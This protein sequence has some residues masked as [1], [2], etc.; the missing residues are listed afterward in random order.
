MKALIDIDRIKFSDGLIPAVIQDVHN[1]DV[2]MVAYMN[3]E[4][5]QLS[6]E[7]GETHFWSRSRKQLWHK[8]ETSG[9]IQKI[10]TIFVDC[11]QD[12]LL[13]E[14]EQVEAACH[15]GKR[16]CF[17]EKFWE[18]NVCEGEEAPLITVQVL[19]ALSQ[20]IL[21]RKA[22]PS[23]ESYTS[24][25]FEGGLDLIL[26]KVAEES[27]E[28]IISAK[29][30]RE[31]EIV[32]ETADLLYHLLVTLGYYGIPMKRIEDELKKRT[33]QSGLAEKESREKSPRRPPE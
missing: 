4:S 16:S 32:H 29:N 15:T 33:S 17:F 20:T 14:V 10:K 22:Y 18:A 25:L 11:D 27:G 30:G 23:P 31:K 1:K 9:H 2:L 6:L 12:T 8:G 19:E 28:F 13:V 5:L 24:S 26:K 3:A 21:Q 7:T